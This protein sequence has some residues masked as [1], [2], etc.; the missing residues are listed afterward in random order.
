MQFLANSSRSECDRLLYVCY[1][2]QPKV[3]DFH[4]KVFRALWNELDARK[5][6]RMY[7]PSVHIKYHNYVLLDDDNYDTSDTEWT[8]WRSI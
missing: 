3:P 5:E 1:T 2:A 7:E 6:H 8:V 4:V